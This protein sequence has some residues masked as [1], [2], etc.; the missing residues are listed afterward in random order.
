MQLIALA[1][2]N[3]YILF[4]DDYKKSINDAFYL[5]SLKDK[6]NSVCVLTY[7]GKTIL[8]FTLNSENKTQTMTMDIKKEILFNNVTSLLS[9]LKYNISKDSCVI[10][11][12]STPFPGT[13]SS[14]TSSNKL[15]VNNKMK[16][17]IF[18]RDGL[19]TSELSIP[20][21]DSAKAMFNNEEEKIKA[22][23]LDNK[24][25]LDITEFNVGPIRF[26]SNFNHLYINNLASKQFLIFAVDETKFDPQVSGLRNIAVVD[27][28]S[29]NP[30]CDDIEK[31]YSSSGITAR[32][33]KYK[34]NYFLVDRYDPANE[35]N[36]WLDLTAKLRTWN[37]AEES[38]SQSTQ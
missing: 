16:A 27:F 18:A 15:F 3:D 8:G 30:N 23:V 11:S 10:N 12:Q 1:G 31:A 22:F 20:N 2:N 38:T 25:D 36:Y 5:D 6:I 9:A 32:C 13:F 14:C 29:F 33:I 21:L 24:D 17:I 19:T 4:C 28:N 26:L 7:K 37:P 34:N 35:K